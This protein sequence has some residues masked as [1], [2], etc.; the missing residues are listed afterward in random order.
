MRMGL[1]FFISAVSLSAQIVS[2]G[3]KTG[4][5]LKDA[6]P[7]QSIYSGT[8]DTKL[9]G[10]PTIE[11]HLPH[12][13]SIEVDALFRAYSQTSLYAFPVI[14]PGADGGT[15][16]SGGLSSTQTHIR[17]QEF[18]LLLK[19]RFMDGPIRPFVS[20]GVDVKRQTENSSF[21]LT[22]LSTAVNCRSN[23]GTFN[24]TSYH[25]YS[26]AGIGVDF[27]AG[28]V[29]IEPEVRYSR[30]SNPTTNQV[31]ALVGFRFGK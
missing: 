6:T 13:F 11:F 2:F 10:G 23:L 21:V 24:D 25:G 26:V 31:T 28:L 30:G 4:V 19:Y 7:P 12:R 27:K 18:P 3:V 20:V 5:I 22:C 9:T 14:P 8:S 16:F 1:T 17:T 29:H 15:L